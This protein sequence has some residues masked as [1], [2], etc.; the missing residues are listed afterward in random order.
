MIVYN[1]LSVMFQIHK[2]TIKRYFFNNIISL[3]PEILG[4]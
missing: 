1:C 4:P 3:F 2:E